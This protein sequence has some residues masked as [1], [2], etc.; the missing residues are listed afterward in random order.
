MKD[1]RLP[2]LEFEEVLKQKMIAVAVGTS[3]RVPERIAP[4]HVV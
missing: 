1:N 4:L 2:S 3:K